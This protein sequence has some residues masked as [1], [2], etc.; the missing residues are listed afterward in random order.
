[1]ILKELFSAAGAGQFPFKIEEFAF[2]FPQ[3]QGFP[4]SHLMFGGRSVL[5]GP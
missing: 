3:D 5:L 4:Q 1:M 2:S